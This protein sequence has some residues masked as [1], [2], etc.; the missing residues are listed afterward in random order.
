[1]PVITLHRDRFNQ[2]L[3]KELT[4]EEIAKWLPW[5]GTDIEDV[6]PDY[7]KVEYNPNRLDFSSHAGLARALKGL[8]GIEVGMPKYEAR[9]SGIVLNIDPSVEKVRPYALAGVVRGLKLDDELVRELMDMQEDLHWGVCRDRRKAAIG[10][11]N[12][13]VLEPPFTYTTVGPETRFVPLD[14]TREMSMVEILQEHKKGRAYAHLLSHTDRYPV[15]VDAKGRIF[16]FPPIINSELTR[17]TAETRNLF[18]DI[19]GPSM[20]AVRNGLNI[21]AST[22]A[23]MGGKLETVEVRYP[24]KT[25]ISPDLTPQEMTLRTEYARE[26]LGLELTD[27]DVIECLRRS[28]L[29]A[30][31]KSEGVIGVRIPAY[32]IDIL[33]EVD[34]VEEVA[35]GYGFYRI[36]PTRPVSTTSGRQ[37][38]TIKAMNCVRVI[39]VGLGFTEAV[40]FILTNEDVHYRMMRLPAGDAIRL[41]NPASA[42]YSITRTLLLPGL[43]QNLAINRHESYPQRLFEVSDVIVRRDDA[44]TRTERRVHVA[45][46]SAHARANYTEMRSYLDAL[47]RSLGLSGWDV[48]E[49]THPSFLEGRTAKILINGEEAAIIGEIHPEVL[50]NFGLE[51]PVAAFEVDLETVMGAVRKT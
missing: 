26:L 25:L 44:E 3:G 12:L 39:M 34:L 27:E 51:T 10:L 7:V 28:R 8:L 48:S 30:W 43:M 41:A 47:L 1:M 18:I 37:H 42:L 4:T 15:M 36:T 6:G 13:D 14:E 24:D 23:D 38:P 22:L 20:D 17:V 16:T 46:V 49:A 32:R 35:L 45:A 50:N 5:L 2:Y 21:L 29:D 19:T 11:H 9:P 31:V 33:H 40:N